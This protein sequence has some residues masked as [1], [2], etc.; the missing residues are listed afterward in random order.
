MSIVTGAT[1]TAFGFQTKTKTLGHKPLF[2][3]PSLAGRRITAGFTYLQR[4][5]KSASIDVWF[6]DHI[7]ESIDDIL[8]R[9]EKPESADFPAEWAAVRQ[10]ELLQESGNH[11]IYDFDSENLARSLYEFSSHMRAGGYRVTVATIGS[12]DAMHAGDD[13]AILDRRLQNR[14]AHLI[15]IL[16]LEEQSEKINVALA[17]NLRLEKWDYQMALPHVGT[18]LSARD[19]FRPARA[20][21]LSLADRKHLRA[22]HFFE[23]LSLLPQRHIV[24]ETAV[25]LQLPESIN[26]NQWIYIAPTAKKPSIASI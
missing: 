12:Y 7:K 17:E 10:F 13:L 18:V 21:K 14:I 5:G 4:I 20:S 9:G 19:V 26:E 16:Y 23:I 15:N 2:A 22:R 11:K 25:G 6:P 3:S 1:Y 24:H 8:A